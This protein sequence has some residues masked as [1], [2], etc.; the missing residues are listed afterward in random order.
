MFGIE[1]I[2][3]SRERKRSRSRSRDRERHRDRDRDRRRD[4]RSGPK[5][6]KFWD[7]PPSGF[8]H[9]S[10]KEY[11]ALQGEKKKFKDMDLPEL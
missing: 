2:N 6:Y 5:K 10:P 4:D 8:E 9:M 11:K 3:I 7:V 1:N